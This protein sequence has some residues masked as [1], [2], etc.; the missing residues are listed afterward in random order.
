[1]LITDTVHPPIAS[2]IKEIQTRTLL[3][4]HSGCAYREKFEQ[5]LYQEKM[6]PNKKMEFG[7]IDGIIG[8]VQLV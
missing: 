6:I 4:F 1:M 2:S 7:T 5:G 3:V 8:C